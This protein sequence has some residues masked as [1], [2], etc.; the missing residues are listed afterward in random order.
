MS[1]KKGGGP[2][3]IPKFV[4]CEFGTGGRGSSQTLICPIFKNDLRTKGDLWRVVPPQAI[5]GCDPSIIGTNQ[6]VKSFFYST[7]IVLVCPKF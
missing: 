1:Q 7:K 3:Q 5:I 2:D 6:K 4:G